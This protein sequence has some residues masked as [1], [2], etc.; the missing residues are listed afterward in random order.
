LLEHQKSHIVDAVRAHTHLRVALIEFQL[1]TDGTRDDWWRA[2]CLG[3]KIF[4]VFAINLLYTWRAYRPYIFFSF[5]RIFICFTFNDIWF[6]S[7]SRQQRSI[8][9][10]RKKKLYQ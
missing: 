3:L 4:S 1:R 7:E 8:N 9:N 5:A 6:I 10:L 2:T